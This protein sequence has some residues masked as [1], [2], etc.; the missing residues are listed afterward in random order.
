MRKAAE[1]G[2]ADACLQLANRMYLDVPYAREVGHV[3]EAAGVA[4]LA[5]VIEGHDVPLDVLKSVVYW[6]QKGRHNPIDKLDALRSEVLEGG[7]YCRNDGCDVVAPLK[8]FKVC[9]Q[10]KTARYCSDA[11]Q[12]ADWTTGGHKATCG[13]TKVSALARLGSA[14]LRMY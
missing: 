6:L 10:C 9:P 1:T 8:E 12:K 7:R 2:D 14:G 11:C 13:S 3:G 5:G 4:T